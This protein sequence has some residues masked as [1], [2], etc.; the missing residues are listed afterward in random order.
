MSPSD[1]L[2]TA[3]EQFTKQFSANVQRGKCDEDEALA[4]TA[5]MQASPKLKAALLE[6]M[7]MWSSGDSH[8]TSKRAQA[9]RAAMW[10]LAHEAIAE[11]EGR[12]VYPVLR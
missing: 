11:S 2:R 5:M 6:F 1:E 9:R 7:D 12:R 8:K 3:V 4:A 10:D